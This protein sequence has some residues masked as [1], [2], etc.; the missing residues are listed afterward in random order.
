MG[1]GV[2][3]RLGTIISAQP[4]EQAEARL[5]LQRSYKHFSKRLGA[6]N[7]LVGEGQAYV[8]LIELSLLLEGHDAADA[9]TRYSGTSSQALLWE[10]SGPPSANG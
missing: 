7:P 4:G 8:A 9:F 10:H 6:D 2:G 3:C 1:A 5:L